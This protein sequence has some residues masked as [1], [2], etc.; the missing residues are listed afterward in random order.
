MNDFYFQCWKIPP[1]GFLHYKMDIVFYISDS[2]FFKAI[3]RPGSSDWLA[4]H[5]ET[6]QSFIQFTRA[7]RNI[8]DSRRKVLYILP[9]KFFE[10]DVPE[11]ITLDLQQFASFFFGMEVKLMKKVSDLRETIPSRINEYTENVQVDAG[12]ILDVMKAIVPPDA[13]CVG[14]LTLC[15]IYPK[16]DWN[17]VFGLATLGARVGVYSL[18]R[19][20][21]GFPDEQVETAN[22]TR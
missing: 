13:F 9:V 18:A 20:M 21:P 10:N 19:L 17:F 14:A 6:G 8:P 1:S 12:K 3:P 4:C 2:E 16:D 15:D 22:L 11:D 7:A 5:K